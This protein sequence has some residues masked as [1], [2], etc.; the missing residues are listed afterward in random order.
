MIP[1]TER[2]L[3]RDFV[4]TDWQAMLA[5]QQKPLY[6]RYNPWTER[7]AEDV[8]AFLQMFLDN[9]K[10]EPRNKFQ[11][12]VTL[13]STGQL[14]GN[15][16]VRR[17][18]A[19]AFEGDIGYELD[20]DHW[21]KGYATAATRP[22]LKFGFEEMKLHRICAYCVPENTASAHVL[23]KLGMRLEGHLRENRFYKNRWWDSL[24]YAMLHD[25]WR[26]QNS[27][28]AE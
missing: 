4:E 16:G 19:D 14:I 17:E 3:L 18:S 13:K 10:E 11:L 25:E 15:C 24:V 6:L 1:S 26:T 28:P 27:D 7:S 23:E 22:I 20:P 12:A 9:Q 2:L 5:Y 21:G 8:R